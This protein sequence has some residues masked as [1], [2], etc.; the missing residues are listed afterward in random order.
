M[1]HAS[2]LLRLGAAALTGLL[3][4]GILVAT[5]AGATSI[6]TE[7]CS[8]GYWKN[9]LDS[10]EEYTPASTVRNQHWIASTS[11]LAKYNAWTFEQALQGGGG[12]GIDGAAKIL[13]R[14]STAAYLN[15]A[16]EGVGYPYRRFTDPGTLKVQIQ[17]AFASLD[18]DQILALA[19]MLDKANNLGCPL[20]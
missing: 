1:T 18:R 13:L 4:G 17:T 9:H 7:G 12:P 14:A 8:P 6:G 10:W 19:S 11:P 3:V 15:A 20:S 16:H 2:R 5:P